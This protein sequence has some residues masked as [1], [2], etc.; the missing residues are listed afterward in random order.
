MIRLNKIRSVDG[1]P[2]P[3]NRRYRYGC[4]LY[5]IFA[6]RR[7]YCGDRFR[8]IKLW[9]RYRMI[10]SVARLRFRFIVFSFFSS[11]CSRAFIAISW[12]IFSL[13]LFSC[14]R[15]SSSF[16]RYCSKS[17]FGASR[18]EQHFWKME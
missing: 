13:R 14:S 16:F 4:D 11:F 10:S 8:A 9:S 3:C 6:F 15:F 7:M 5:K 2:N 17:I 18:D 1:K 12:V